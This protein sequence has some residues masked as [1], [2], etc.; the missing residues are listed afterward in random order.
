[1]DLK[2][3]VVSGIY[4]MV[5]AVGFEPTT[6]TTRTL[7]AARLRYAPKQGNASSTIAGGAR[8]SRGK[9][10]G[11]LSAMAFFWGDGLDNFGAY[12]FLAE[13]GAGDF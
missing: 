12:L 6:S 2:V 10:R 7:R 3:T 1:M 4:Q 5:G 9:A 11:L 8:R 13:I